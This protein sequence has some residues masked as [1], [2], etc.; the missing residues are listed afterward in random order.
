M[1]YKDYVNILND[2]GNEF[3]NRDCYLSVKHIGSKKN[4]SLD[5][6]QVIFLIK[7]HPA[8]QIPLMWVLSQ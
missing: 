5:T 3:N 8:I 2:N 1:K 7:R 6:P 4:T